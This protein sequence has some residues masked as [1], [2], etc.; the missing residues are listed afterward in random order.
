ML[1][2][3][4]SPTGVARPIHWQDFDAGAPRIPGAPARNMT[5]LAGTRLDGFLDLGFDGFQ[6]EACALLHRWKLDRSLRELSHFLLY[7]L[8]APELVGK[9]VV[10]CQRPLVAVG[11]TRA[12]ERI[13]T[14]IGEDRPVNLD[15]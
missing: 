1:M 9:P 15:R 14:E 12:L 5:L 2:V 8:E 3:A 7:K 11:Q 10:E 6:I 13:E 4:S